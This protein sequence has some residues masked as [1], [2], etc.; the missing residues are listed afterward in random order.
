LALGEVQIELGLTAAY[1]GE[2]G[3]RVDLERLKISTGKPIA[4]LQKAGKG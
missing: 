2:K 1:G 4:L 3:R